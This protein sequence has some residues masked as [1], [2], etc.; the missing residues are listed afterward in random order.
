MEL[1][2][3]LGVFLVRI[4]LRVNIFHTIEYMILLLGK[5]L[6]SLYICILL[7]S[8]FCFFLTALIV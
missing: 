6:S 5:I 2:E 4:S 1:I 8:T 7:L 3:D